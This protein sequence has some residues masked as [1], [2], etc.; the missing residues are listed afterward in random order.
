LSFGKR[1]DKMERAK[2]IYKGFVGRIG[3]VAIPHT[4]IV[5]DGMIQLGKVRS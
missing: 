2:E 5:V 3:S 4:F 1:G